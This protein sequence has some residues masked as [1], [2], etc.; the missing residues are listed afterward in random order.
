M[1]NT[2]F[3]PPWRGLFR[4]SIRESLAHASSVS[5]IGTQETRAWERPIRYIADNNEGYVGVVEFGP[6]GAIGAM[7][8]RDVQFFDRERA[9]AAA[10]LGARDALLRLCDLPLLQERQGVSMVFWSVGESILGPARW[11]DLCSHGAQVFERELLSDSAW[12]AEAVSHFE[13]T[14]EVTRLAI[15]IA[16]RATIQVPLVHLSNRELNTLIDPG[17]NYRDEAFDLLFSDGLFV[18]GDVASH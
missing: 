11:H 17:C 9:I 10:P 18:V 12:E 8:S 15:A 3:P 5:R 13:L 1:D 6:E 16:A 2:S 4:G 14:P 7:N